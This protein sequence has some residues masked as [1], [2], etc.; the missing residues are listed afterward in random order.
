MPSRSEKRRETRVP[1]ELWIEAERDGELYYQRAVNLSVGGAFFAQTVPM[2]VG[3]R[4][5][6]KFALPG[7][8]EE[9][10]CHGEIVTAKALG[11]GV[12]FIELSDDARARIERAVDAI[13]ARLEAASRA[14]P[15]QTGASRAATPRPSVPRGKRTPHG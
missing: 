12:H 6:L 9:I 10:A 4:V 3:T 13:A 7:D 15:A 2:P 8:A 14:S 11:M 5:T 1:A